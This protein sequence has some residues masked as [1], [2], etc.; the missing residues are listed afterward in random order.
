MPQEALPRGLVLL[1]AL[2]HA[3]HLPVAVRV[4]AD[5]DEH[6]H[7]AHLAAPAALQPQAVEEDVGMRALDRLVP[8]GLDLASHLLVELADSGGA[9]ARAPQGLR[10]VLDPA[11]GHPGVIHLQERLLHGGLPA[12]VA[13]NDGRLE[14]QRAQLGDLQRDL[15]GCVWNCRSYWPARVSVRSGLCL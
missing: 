8:P 14:W 5:G 12:L 11:H 9:D 15:A 7:V 2:G 6:A 10:D 4:D 3:E 13:L 1:R